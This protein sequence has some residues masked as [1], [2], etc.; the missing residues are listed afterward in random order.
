LIVRAAGWVGIALSVGY[1]ATA[2]TLEEA[3]ERTLEV[4]GL[5]SG[6]EITAEVAGNI[7][8]IRSESRRTTLDWHWQYAEPPPEGGEAE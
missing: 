6:V 7:A 1:V 8:T 2:P 5:T 3:G 4:S